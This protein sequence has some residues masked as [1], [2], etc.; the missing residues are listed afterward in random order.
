MASLFSDHA[1]HQ[2]YH[3]AKKIRRHIRSLRRE[4]IN[5]NIVVSGYPKSG[6]TW[7]ARM[8][9][10]AASSELVAYLSDHH[11]NLPRERGMVG[12]EVRQDISTIKSHHSLPLLRLGGVP[13]TDIAIIVRDPRDVAVS[14]AGFFFGTENLPTSESID[15]MID[16]MLAET[17][18]SVR[19]NDQRWDRFVERS[20]SSNVPVIRYVD[21]VEH[22][23]TTL[24]PILDHLSLELQDEAIEQL[25]NYHSFDRAKKRSTRAGQSDISHHLRTGKSG[26]YKIYLSARQRDRIESEFRPVMQRLGFL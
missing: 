14:G 1:W 9:A 26:E 7:L 5:R 21:L 19:W 23:A 12:S 11:E 25:V 2:T 8:L 15:Q 22:T 4:G 13:K 6:N 20:F 17:K 24:K 18:P 3:Q 10:D 16:M